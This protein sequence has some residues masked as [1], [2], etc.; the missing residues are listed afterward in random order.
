M[1]INVTVTSWAAPTSTGT[2]ATTAA[3][4]ASTPPTWTWTRG[5]QLGGQTEIEER[6]GQLVLPPAQTLWSFF[7][8]ALTRR[9]SLQTR[10]TT[11]SN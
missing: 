5:G 7:S 9:R 3:R 11:T 8:S 6:D 2:S 4:L 1:F 10:E